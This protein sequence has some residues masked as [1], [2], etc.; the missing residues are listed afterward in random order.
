MPRNLLWNTEGKGAM[1]VD[2]ERAKVVARKV[3]KKRTALGTISGNQRSQKKRKMGGKLD[4]E[5]EEVN[6][7]KEDML[8][9]REV[10]DMRVG[11]AQCVQ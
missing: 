1:V 5:T 11:L 2:F 4:G 10:T 7:R 3:T 9:T 8:Y 6:Q